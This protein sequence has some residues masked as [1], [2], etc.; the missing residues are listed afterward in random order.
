MFRNALILFALSTLTASAV[1]AQDHGA[2]GAAADPTALPSICL[3]NADTSHA[4]H[5]MGSGM[6]EGPHPDLMVGMDDMNAQMMAGAT[7]EDFDVAFVCSM[8]P[9][10]RGAI[11]MAEAQIANGD[12]PWAR[13]LAETIIEAQEAEIADMIAWLEQQQ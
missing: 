11:A 8:I 3:E 12:D 7:A 4:G 10:H 1:M 6:A 2:H 13:E 5:D 9:H